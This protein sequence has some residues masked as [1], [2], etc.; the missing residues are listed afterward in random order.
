MSQQAADEGFVSLIGAGPGDV[1]L[2]SRRAIDRLRRADVVYYDYLAT[3]LLL[4][5]APA[6]AELL[7]VGKR[8]GARSIP[9]SA[10]Q[11]L[12]VVEA[13][14]GKRV[15]RLKGGDPY[16]FGRGGEEAARL[17]AEGIAFE[18]VPGVSSALAV[19][20]YA[21][22]PVTDRRVASSVLIATGHEDPERAER[23]VRWERAGQAS[24]TLVILMA[25]RRLDQICRELVEHGRP[26]STPATAI[27]W[28]ATARQRRVVASLDQLAAA[29]DTAGIGAPAV[30][31]VGDVVELGPKRSEFE[32]LP[33]FGCRIGITRDRESGLRLAE[34]LVE[35]GAEPVLAP[36]IA[37]EP[38]SD[39]SGLLSAVQQL[40]RY[41]LVCFTSG[42]TVRAFFEALR[43]SGG[44][45]RR[46][47]SAL[48]AA[49]GSATAEALADRGIVT[50]IVPDK[51]VAESLLAALEAR[52]GVSGAR[53]L[54]PRA[55][56]AREMLPDALRKRGAVVD[57]AVAYRNVP[58][59][60]GRIAELGQRVDHGDID[61]VVFTSS[62]TFT[63]LV[64][65]WGGIDAARQR[66]SR[67]A[68]ASIGPVTTATIQASGLGATVE[69]SVH[70]VDGLVDALQQWWAEAGEQRRRRTVSW[71]ESAGADAH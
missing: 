69:A 66:L 38:A 13:R 12:L 58:A 9:Q 71:C 15:V 59:D 41:D 33:L 18:V 46:F 43:A 52:G 4:D 7:H 14:A 26:A 61:A 67:V 65:G 10:I 44:D 23:R 64:D 11:D 54:L 45:A 16:L 21:G 3:P 68:L 60:P 57:I 63:R 50:D 22:I 70:T 8:V 31:V 1:G 28:G 48:V 5:Y 37:F 39:P 29:A 30:I 32:R 24:D 6:H 40:S 62:S 42:N 35:V 51:F 27:M 2:V 34:R 36:T 53:I 17:R 55:E 49:V 20:A 56:V 25:T 19:P 47:G